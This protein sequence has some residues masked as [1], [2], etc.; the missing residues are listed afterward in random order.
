MLGK[1]TVIVSVFSNWASLVLAIVMAFI[2]SPILVNKLGDETYGIWVIIVS[3]TGYF[4]V[5]DFGVNTAIVRFIS[6]Y[7]A[8]KNYTKAIETYSSSFALF[9]IIGTV[10][11]IATAIFAFFFKEAFN[12]ESFSRAYLYLV[13]FI[14]GVDLALNL[15][16]SV[17]MG[18]LKG[19]QRFFELNV[20]SMSTSL[21]RNVLLVYLLYQ[22]YSLLMLA[23]L[24]VSSSIIRFLL[25]YGYLKKQYSF[26]KF[27]FSSVNKDTLKSLYNY[28]IY[29]FLIA[30]ATKVLFFTDSIVIGSM[31]NVSQVTYYAIPGMIVEYL[32]KFIWAIVAV[33]IPII[34]SQEAVGEENKNQRLYLVGTKYSLLLISPILLVLYVVGDDFIGMW[35]GASYAQPSGEILSI[36][37]IGYVFFLAQLIAHGILKG[38]SK[39]KV[40]ALM[41][42][43]E[44]VVNLGL[45]VW[46][47]PL[48][49]IKGVAIGTTIP[50]VA[51]NVIWLPLYTCKVLQLNYF[52]YLR[53]AIVKP[54]LLL[55]VALIVFDRLNINVSSYLELVFFSSAV[56]IAYGL[57]ALLFLMEKTHSNRIF[58][59]LKIKVG[60]GS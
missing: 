6:K 22:D 23:I 5:L 2:V 27:S 53:D 58:N 59:L 29:S 56:A 25:Q 33:L 11:V 10:V 37:L 39:H 55:I 34:S 36:L 46:L 40:L 47:A 30:I 13:F 9:F 17:L 4:T 15:V 44:A 16:F 35:M 51:A 31:I 24:Q 32:E 42:C 14:V 49:G 7:T 50:L 52:C 19:L 12:I 48:Y 57:C 26:L 28:S 54:L 20:I 41:L 18:T 1:N 38:I 45:S 8:L 3:V 60:S 43:G 21:V